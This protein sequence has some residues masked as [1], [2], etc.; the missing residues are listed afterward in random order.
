MRAE[1]LLLFAGRPVD[2]NRTVAA[3]PLLTGKPLTN[4]ADSPNINTYQQTAQKRIS[5]SCQP[6]PERKP[7]GERLLSGGGRTC[8]GA[9]CE[10]RV[11]GGRETQRTFGVN[12]KNEES[13]ADGSSFG[14][15]TA[16]RVNQ[17][18]TAGFP[19][20]WHVSEGGCWRGGGPAF[21]YGCPLHSPDAPSHTFLQ[22]R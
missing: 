2:S 19:V 16:V 17:G 11:S 4:P 1:R 9:L 5:T 3:Q 6:T 7:S 8:L 21:L 13:A 18:G 15:K 22:A 10:D 14:G 12:E 20:P